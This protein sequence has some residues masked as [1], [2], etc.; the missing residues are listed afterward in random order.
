MCYP[1]LCRLLFG[2]TK[3]FSVSP[4]LATDRFTC[5]YRATAFGLRSALLV[6]VLDCI[7]LVCLTS[8]LL[9]ALSFVR[10]LGFFCS[11]RL[12]LNIRNV[13]LVCM[14]GARF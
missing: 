14:V 8:S 13:E 4:S 6:N 7:W 5:G 12:V 1:V 2:S 10:C 3:L 9:G 11:G